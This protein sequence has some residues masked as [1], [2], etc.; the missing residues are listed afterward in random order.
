LYNSCGIFVRLT[1]NELR[2]VHIEHDALQRQLEI[3]RSICIISSFV[4][5]EQGVVFVEKYDKKS[6]Y[7]ML[8]KCH[9]HF[10]SFGEIKY[11]FY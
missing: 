6:L 9:E 5:R 7:F 8:V 1:V 10:A 11:K 3:K 4:K 2:F